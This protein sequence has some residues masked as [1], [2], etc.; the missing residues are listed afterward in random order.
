MV[1]KLRL[2]VAKWRDNVL[3]FAKNTFGDGGVNLSIEHQ[4]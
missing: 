3:S 2:A 1:Y 4:K